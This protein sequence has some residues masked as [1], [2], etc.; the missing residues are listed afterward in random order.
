MAD[1][2]EPPRRTGPM[3][4]ACACHKGVVLV[5]VVPCCGPAIGDGKQQDHQSAGQR[6]ATPEDLEIRHSRG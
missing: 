3:P 4:C 2:S 6:V 5:H 1:N